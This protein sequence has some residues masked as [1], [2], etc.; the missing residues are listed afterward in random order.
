VDCYY[1]GQFEL[2]TQKMA[3][4]YQEALPS[5]LQLNETHQDTSRRTANIEC[6][7]LKKCRREVRAF[8]SA[9]G[10][11]GFRKAQRSQIASARSYGCDNCWRYT[12][13][14]LSVHLML[15]QKRADCGPLKMRSYL[16]LFAVVHQSL[17]RDFLA[18]LTSAAIYWISGNLTE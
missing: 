8:P 10:V 7:S 16:C 4:S 2:Y 15:P 11:N 13:A 17:P 18:S 9:P 1:R 14:P 5:S 12:R 6:F 3:T